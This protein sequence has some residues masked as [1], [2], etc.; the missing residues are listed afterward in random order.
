MT[1]E[2]FYKYIKQNFDVNDVIL[3]D[4]HKPCKSVRRCKHEPHHPVVDFDDIKKKYHAGLSG[5][6]PASVDG[7]TFSGRRLC[8]VEMKGWVEFLTHLRAKNKA[9]AIEKKAASYDLN[10]KLFDSLDICEVLSGTQGQLSDVPIT[11]VLVTDIETE[12][13]GLFMFHSNLL[14]LADPA[15]NWIDTCNKELRARLDAIP[16]NIPTVYISCKDFDETLAKLA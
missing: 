15:D 6:T 11:F 13:N 2:Q 7:I 10:K 16:D 4:L 8:F 3:C 9:I 12:S 14:R 1:A 5:D